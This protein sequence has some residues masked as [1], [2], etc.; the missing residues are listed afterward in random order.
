MGSRPQLRDDK[1]LRHE[2][3][4]TMCGKKYTVQKGN[5]YYSQ[6]PL[7]AGNEQ[8]MSIC[9]RCVDNLFEDYKEGLGDEEEAVKRTCCKLDMYYS[10]DIYEEYK[11]VL[12]W[13]NG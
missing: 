10:H 8:Y 2:F 4:C 6:S 9:K 13:L 5:F 3:H 1:E 12:G 11:K 7:Y